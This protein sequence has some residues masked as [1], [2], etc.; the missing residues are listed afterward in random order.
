MR[1]RWELSGRLWHC[2]CELP[3]STA[4]SLEKMALPLL[5]L[6]VAQRPRRPQAALAPRGSRG[7]AASVS[8]PL[9]AVT[10]RAAGG[11]RPWQAPQAMFGIAAPKMPSLS[12]AP[13]PP[14]LSHARV[15]ALTMKKLPERQ[16][17]RHSTPWSKRAGPPV[18]HK[19]RPVSKKP[20]YLRRSMSPFMHAL[21]QSN[22]HERA[23]A[24]MPAAQLP[25]MLPAV[26]P[27]PA[28]DILCSR[29]GVA[30]SIPTT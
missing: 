24:T 27:S 20:L 22:G 16:A 14:T 6:P 13:N 8:S 9:R 23:P 1:P 18:R 29:R 19:W 17:Q 26:A 2:H 21:M 5:T 15:A 3:L 4:C 11:L 28:C 7:G 12:S 25:N 10:R 30:L